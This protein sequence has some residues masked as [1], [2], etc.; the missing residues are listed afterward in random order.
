MYFLVA[1]LFFLVGF[2]GG[3][4]YSDNLQRKA[5]QAVS[6]LPPYIHRD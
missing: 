6:K 3:V 1:V 4:I 5:L 2:T